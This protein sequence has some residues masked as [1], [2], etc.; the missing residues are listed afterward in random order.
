[1]HKKLKQQTILLFNIAKDL[2]SSVLLTG[3]TMEL[4]KMT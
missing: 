1:M 3:F 4:A 2:L